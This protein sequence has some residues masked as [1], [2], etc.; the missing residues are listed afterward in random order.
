[1][2][3]R[4]QFT[5]VLNFKKVDSCLPKVEWA[6]WWDKTLDRWKTEGMP[7]NLNFDESLEYFSLEKFYCLSASALSINCPREK[8]HGTGIITDKNSYEEIKPF[9]YTDSIIENLKKIAY[10][11]KEKHD[12]GD[13]IIRLWL[14]GFFWHPR[15]L[16]GIEAHLYAFYDHPE[17]M[18]E[19]NS[20]LA[21]FNI[22]VINEL[23]PILK[24][25]MVGFAED[26]SY[27]H[28]SMLSYDLF[29]EFLLPYYKKVIPHI[30]K[31]G[32]KVLIDSDGDITSMIPWMYEASIDGVYPLER[33][34]GVDI[35]KIREKYPD[36]LM[37]G[38]YDKMV[39]SKDEAAMRSEFER[40]LPVMRSGG[41]IPSV[42]HQT[43]P[44]VSLDNYRIYIRLLKEYC[45]KAAI[46]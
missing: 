3:S 15:T 22:K 11:I 12:N 30:K 26:M 46:L 41:Y 36:F 35:V 5:N 2:N 20:H 23:F 34:A 4:E 28:G 40:I 44:E 19:I 33:Q 9:L 43:P 45:E 7:Q 29:K 13:I 39:M 16:L 1:M 8:A 38:G 37:L 14:D 25:D 32:V 42:D 27:N 18:H 17:L 31:H 10:D 6:A 21:D 24:P